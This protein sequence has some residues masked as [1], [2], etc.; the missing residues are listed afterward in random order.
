MF[1]Q[2]DAEGGGCE[3]VVVLFMRIRTYKR[4]RLGPWCVAIVCRFARQSSPC[5][6]REREST[7]MP[8]GQWEIVVQ[9]VSKLY[10]KDSRVEAGKPPFARDACDRA[11]DVP[12]Q[13]KSTMPGCQYAY[14]RS[15]QSHWVW[16]MIAA[17]SCRGTS[18]AV[19]GLVF[20]PCHLCK[21][22][23]PHHNPQTQTCPISSGCSQ[24][25]HVHRR[26]VRCSP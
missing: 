17:P 8:A 6:K 3:R 26:Q 22:H 13:R 9:G 16:Q 21:H 1:D 19:L 23:W 18:E 4:R 25:R 11:L 10:T 20:S 5:D 15:Q 14:G 7:V 2:A 12:L 24:Y